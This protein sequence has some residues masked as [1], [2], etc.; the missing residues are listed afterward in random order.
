MEPLLE[1]KLDYLELMTIAAALG[2]LIEQD[3]KSKIKFAQANMPDL[4]TPRINSA[5]KILEQVRAEKEWY[6][7][8]KG[9]K[10]PV[11][12]VLFC[13]NCGIQ[14]IDKSEPDKCET[15]GGGRTNCICE[16]F[17]EWLNPPHAKHR[18]KACNHVWKPFDYPTNGV[19]ETNEK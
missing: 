3:K 2:L 4:A 5:E 7:K 1:L 12:V 19:F 17:T 14:H 15:C 16:F 8:T 11:D 9:I 18:C 13:P 10:P 6:I